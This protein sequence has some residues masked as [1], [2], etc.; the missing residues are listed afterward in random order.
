M[1]YVNLRE[2]ESEE[3]CINI[4]FLFAEEFEN[5]EDVGSRKE[6]AKNFYTKMQSNLDDV[7]SSDE[8]KLYTVLVKLN[9]LRFSES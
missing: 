7:K 4:A 2:I 9:L 3:A 6:K 5:N 8:S 1:D